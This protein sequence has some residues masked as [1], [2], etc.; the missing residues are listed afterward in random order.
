MRLTDQKFEGAYTSKRDSNDNQ[1]SKQLPPY[2]KEAAFLLSMNAQ[3]RNDIFLFAGSNA[4]QQAQ[5]F[6]KT[7]VVLCLPPDKNPFDYLWPVNDCSILLFDTGNLSLID[8]DKIAYCLLIANAAIVRVIYS[9]NI[10]IIYR[11]DAI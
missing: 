11:R 2:G 5:A 1:F 9:D 6:E 7:Q 3:L 4:W 8:I 10:V